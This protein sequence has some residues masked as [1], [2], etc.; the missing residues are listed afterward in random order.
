MKRV[1]ILGAAAAHSIA[2]ASEDEVMK[3]AAE[4]LGNANHRMGHQ[5][6]ISN[7]SLAEADTE[8]LAST[9]KKAVY[10]MTAKY[11]NEKETLESILELT[12][13]KALVESI[14]SQIES[15]KHIW[16]MQVESIKAQM[17]A[18]AQILKVDLVHLSKTKQEKKAEKI[19]PKP[20]NKI[21]ENGYGGYKS[22]ISGVSEEIKE[23]YPYKSLR[24]TSREAALLCNGKRNILEIKMMLDVQYPTDVELQDLMNYIK[25]LEAAGLVEL[26]KR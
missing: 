7:H 21:R 10:D 3:I 23:K 14:D 8:F 15:L 22:L 25:V 4:I 12:E 16:E 5:L 11:I 20:T 19:I 18:R 6:T 13:N 17:I 24:R 9:Y 1:V 26:E 2:V